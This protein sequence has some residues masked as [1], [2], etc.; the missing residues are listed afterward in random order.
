M[1]LEFTA[2][3]L[4]WRTEIRTWLAANVPAEPLPSM[5]TAEGFAAHRDWERRLHDARWAVVTWP[6]EYGGRGAG[7]LDWLGFEGEDLA[8]G[9]PA[10]GG[11][12]GLFLLAPAIFEFGPPGPKQ[13]FLPP[14]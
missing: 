1:N 2:E 4:A 7:L 5:D 14:V 6:Q 8:P 9:A 13:R 3:Q 12:N 11:P 10:R